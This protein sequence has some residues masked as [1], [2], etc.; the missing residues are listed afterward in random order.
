[1]NELTGQRVFLTGAGG[2]LGAG[3]ARAFAER[4]AVLGISDMSETGLDRVRGE[5]G[6]WARQL[7]VTDAAQVRDVIAEFA[8]T[9][10]GI[11]LLVNNAGL[12][13][14]APVVDLDPADWRRVLEVNA[15]GTF[16]VSQAAVREM[17]VRKAE[18]A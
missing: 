8:G 5:L 15:T 2:G 10:G 16:L 11:D 17:M 3:L 18:A 14:V 7:D 9:H 12:L 13:T 6:C 1:M 4:G